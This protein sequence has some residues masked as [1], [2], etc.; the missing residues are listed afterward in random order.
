MKEDIKTAGARGEDLASGLLEQKGYHI[1]KRN[2]RFGRG[3]IDII[4]KK[5]GL[6]IFFEVKTRNNKEFGEPEYAVTKSKQKQIIRIARA[7]LYENNIT[8][9][10]C[11]FDVIAISFENFSGP[12]INHLENAFSDM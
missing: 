1:I 8:D 4:A 3:E 2:F 11:R 5:D 12:K 7:Y 6:L 9:I 10:Q